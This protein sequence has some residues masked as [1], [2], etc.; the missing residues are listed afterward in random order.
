MH[1]T[2]HV[3]YV[4]FAFKKKKKKTRVRGTSKVNVRYCTVKKFLFENKTKFILTFV[5]D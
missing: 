3:V 5:F 1:Y 4:V 2:A